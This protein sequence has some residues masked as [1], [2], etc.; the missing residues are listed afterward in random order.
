MILFPTM[1]WGLL[2]NLRVV[3]IAQTVAR[4]KRSEIRER[5]RDPEP[6]IPLR[7]IRLRL[8]LARAD[9]VAHWHKATESTDLN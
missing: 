8:L 7:S 9:D 4:M 5:C 3:L 1:G 6:R 2:A